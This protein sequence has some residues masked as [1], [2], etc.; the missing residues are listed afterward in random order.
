MPRDLPLSNGELLI[1]FDK[2]YNLRDIYWPHVGQ[3]LHTV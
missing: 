2:S 3:Q 1:N